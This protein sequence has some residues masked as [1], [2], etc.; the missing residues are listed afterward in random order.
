[1]LKRYTFLIGFL[2][3]FCA[4]N[5]VAQNP[6]K[7]INIISLTVKNKLPA[8]INSWGSI[9]AGLM[10][11]AQKVPQTNVQGI[12][13]VVQIKQ[14][15]SRICGTSVDASQ[16]IDINNVR[17]F[18]ANELIGYLSQ[19][20]NLRPGTYTMCV[21]F[22]NIDRYPIS[23]E[24]CKEFMVE[25]Q[26]QIQQSY[27][28]PQNLAPANQKK[29]ATLEQSAPI[30]FRWTPLVPKPRDPVV[31][32]LR[33]W[34]LMQ[35]QSGSQAMKSNDPV[36]EKD[37]TGIT[38]AII[39]NLYTGPCKPPYLCDFVWNVQALDKEGK[40]LG[41]RNGMSE[42]SSW[43]WGVAQTGTLKLLAPENK[44]LLTPDEN[45]PINFRWTPLVPKPQEPV[46]YRLKVWQLMQGQ[47]STQ[48]MRTNKPIVTK[49]IADITEATIGNI[50]TGPCKPPYLCDYVWSVQALDKEGKSISEEA[51]SSWSFGVTES[52]TLKLLSPG[53]KSVLTGKENAP[54][55]FRWTPL[56]PKPQEPVTYRLK[57]WQLMQGQNSTQAMR[58]NKPIVTKDVA[59]IT[60]SSIANIY[61][62][63]CKPPYLCDYVWSVQV[64][65]KEEKPISEEAV[66]SW[67]FGATQ[68]GA[69]KIMNEENPVQPANQKLRKAAAVD[70]QAA[71]VKDTTV[72]VKN[73][74]LR[75]AA[76]V[77]IQAAK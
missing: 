47:N 68:S 55:N 30:T 27:T 1:M 66:S 15:G 61:T 3:C 23:E 36:I 38:Q 72:P 70:I 59:D 19:C 67:S 34:Q 71:K 43:S 2:L 21:Q 77:D 39:A 60:E 18:T 53:D 9:P 74:K 51:V 41:S 42:L 40:P 57:V 32:R 13:L 35:G 28:A 45:A 46:T 49:D 31:Y 75:K 54:I 4:I 20:P 62:G 22:F 7:Q 52:G 69:T 33:V 16:Q 44:S 10:L 12:K 5:V 65:D 64:L 76:A 26:V 25:D 56:V 8:D 17:N 14:A 6:L 37:V 63:P 11:V 73:Q 58:T 48:A 50:Y 24:R 29:F